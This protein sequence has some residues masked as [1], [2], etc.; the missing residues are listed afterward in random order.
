VQSVEKGEMQKRFSVFYDS[1]LRG[2][3]LTITEDGVPTVMLTAC[4]LPSKRENPK[5]AVSAF[6]DYV[7]KNQFRL[8]G[9]AIQ[10]LIEEGRR[11]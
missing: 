8:E 1:L 9:L 3:S 10:D 4:P 5:E 2:E 11:Y 6:F 7:E